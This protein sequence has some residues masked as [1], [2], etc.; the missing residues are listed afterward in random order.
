M[1]T[2]DQAQDILQ[3]ERL[4]DIADRYDAVL[5]DIWGV[6]HNG[7]ESFPLGSEAL[8]T[9]RRRG[10][11]VVLITNAPRPSAPIARQLQKLG[12]A[13]DAYDAIA[14]SGDVSIELICERIDDPVF[15]IGPGRDLSLFEA[16]AEAAGKR[17]K[18]VALA[19]AA[20]AL[21]TGLRDDVAET[22]DDYEAEL[23]AMAARKL[24]MICANPDIVIHRGDALIYCAG[25]L[26]QRYEHMDGRVVYAGKPHAPIYRRALALAEKAR[27]KI[28]H[29]DRV[30]AIGDGM[31][32]DIA[33]AVDA[34]LDALLVTHGIHRAELHPG[35]LRDEADRQSLQ[36]LCAEY[37]RWPVAAISV[38]RP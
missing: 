4:G 33:G 8:Q 31:K 18:L 14:T 38:L 25:A 6:L 24:T 30:L 26:A 21:C 22:V 19:E 37:S 27:G 10:G 34:G 16:A 13:N 35:S 7:V 12:V 5:C 1:K 2:Q 32:T 3:I 9:F 28:L 20:Y 17:P 15:H 29:N 11:T 36:R 23:L